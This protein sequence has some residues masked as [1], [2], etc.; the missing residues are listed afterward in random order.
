[1]RRVPLLL[2]VKL[3]DAGTASPL[4]FGEDAS[5]AF[6]DRRY[7]F[8]QV[9]RDSIPPRTLQN[10]AE[11]SA[12][13]VLTGP[14]G[15]GKTTSLHEILNHH[16]AGTAEVFVNACE[17]N[18]NRSFVD[19][20]DN[21]AAKKYL[22]SIPLDRQLKRFCLSHRL[23]RK[24]VA[25]R[26]T[27]ATS[28]N[29]NSSRSC[30]IV[31]VHTQ[32]GVLTVV[33]MMGNEK[34]VASSAY[35]KSST[36][37]NSAMSSLTYQLLSG[38]LAGRSHNLVTNLI[39]RSHTNGD[40]KLLL[41]L[42]EAG[43]P[44]LIRSSLTNLADAV[45]TLKLGPFSARS[46]LLQQNVP[47][48][49][50]PTASFLSPSKRMNYRISKPAK[51]QVKH[52]RASLPIKQ[53]KLASLVK[54]LQL[55]LD[56][57]QSSQADP[58][59]NLA[60]ISNHIKHL[61]SRVAELTDETLRAKNDAQARSESQKNELICLETR[62]IDLDSRILSLTSRLDDAAASLTH[63]EQEIRELAE[64]RDS[65]LKPLSQ[66]LEEQK[67]TAQTAESLRLQIS[68]LTSE[69]QGVMDK[70]TAA[71]N[72]VESRDMELKDAQAKRI[73]AEEKLIQLQDEVQKSNL[74]LS[75]L[76]T[77]RDQIIT[78]RDV[79]IAEKANI[80]DERDS[81]KIERTQLLKDL[82][83][84][85][86]QK[87]QMIAENTLLQEQ[88]T[89]QKESVSSENEQILAQNGTLK[90]EKSQLAE[91]NAM[92]K[93]EKKEL[94]AQLNQL[95]QA[96]A[97][98]TGELEAR[99]ASD[100]QQ[101]SRLEKQLQETQASHSS[102]VAELNETISQL[103][104]STKK[105]EFFP[106]LEFT[107]NN[108]AGNNFPAIDIFD[109]HTEYMSGFKKSGQMGPSWAKTPSPRRI[110]QDSGLSNLR[111]TIDGKGRME[112]VNL[113]GSFRLSPHMPSE[114]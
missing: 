88:L 86:I 106:E 41:H 9:F 102:K 35:A 95:Q 105:P 25:E 74:E 14:S 12:T 92:L 20:L 107:T 27:G 109:D 39:F 96:Q 51:P 72:L 18:R 69:K 94:F 22:S 2:K 24:L 44:D 91:S 6:Q 32:H 56:I 53:T 4:S 23:L 75:N 13:I 49:A 43:S 17:I 34:Y 11:S 104:R 16:L 31:I 3:A 48:Y 7:T 114:A 46:P 71:Q 100:K 42:D 112:P 68:E 84:L 62:L 101:V 57:P 87:E 50:R 78:E 85:K 21:H 63:K 8:T 98:R 108:F 64:M 28:S 26:A 59:E 47:N 82:D 10:L 67:L 65:A 113:M 37:A 54:D 77:E 110:L 93:Q 90:L 73:A 38:F 79:T 61:Q 29:P 33:D 97:K 111:S 80:T 89:M 60:V 1:M 30:V 58:S 83:M 52:S 76:K 5:V 66:I 19:L 99:I 55:Q 36:F 103:K 45:T 81:L 15:S 70:L 40:I